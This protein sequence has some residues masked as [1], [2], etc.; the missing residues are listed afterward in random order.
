MV[1]NAASR[2]CA[3][4]GKFDGFLLVRPQP[5]DG[6]VNERSATL[7]QD[8]SHARS[9]GS[10][11]RAL[12]EHFRRLLDENNLPNFPMKIV[13]KNHKT[14]FICN[15]LKSDATSVAVES[16]HTKALG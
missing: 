15:A 14:S 11:N 8:S 3:T 9:H 16:F 2:A 12:P 13:E 7:A 1:V 5:M 10:G 6:V 4:D